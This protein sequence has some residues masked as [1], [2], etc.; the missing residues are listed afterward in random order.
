MRMPKYIVM[1]LVL[2]L[3]QAS[4]YGQAFWGG[5]EYGMSVEQVKRLY[6]QVVVPE[7]PK[8][9]ENGSSEL[10]RLVGLDIGHE[11]FDAHFLFKDMKLSQVTLALKN[12]R[13]FTTSLL[14][15]DNFADAF[16]SKFGKEIKLDV[17]RGNVS[18]ADAI[19]MTGRTNI[20]IYVIGVGDGPSVF[21]INYQTR[22]AATADKL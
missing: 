11:K 9:L 17:N 16:R 20:Q 1:I 22:L 2:T 19:W 10:L 7:K 13:N 3:F 18:S 15:F 8:K 21:N 5:T 14:I 6:P 12:R 4:A